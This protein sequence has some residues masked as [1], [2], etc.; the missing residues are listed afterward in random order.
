MV[1]LPRLGPVT[2]AV[3]RGASQ[4]RYCGWGIPQTDGSTYI[5][6]A[7]IDDAAK[8]ELLGALRDSVYVEEASEE[9]EA[10]FTQSPTQAHQYTDTLLL[11]DDLLIV[12]VQRV[13]GDYAWDALRTVRG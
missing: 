9:V 2:A 11:D 5:A 6:L 12:S 4:Q 1:V 7:V 8:A 13:V 3:V 10:V